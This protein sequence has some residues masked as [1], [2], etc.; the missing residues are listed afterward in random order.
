MRPLATLLF[1]AAC[2]T[3]TT[4]H[5]KG[6]PRGARATEHLVV[7]CPSAEL[8]AAG[9]AVDEVV[10]VAA[11]D[12]VG[13]AA[14]IYR[15]V[16]GTGQDIVVAVGAE[17]EISKRRTIGIVASACEYRHVTVLPC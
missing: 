9:I 1:V 10:P 16:A 4:A 17:Q 7:A 6:G 8:I 2:A 13:S 3:T 12:G 14:G 11:V 5:E 15:I